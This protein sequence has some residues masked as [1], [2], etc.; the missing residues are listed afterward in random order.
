M[1]NPVRWGT[2]REAAEIAGLHTMTI[3]RYI[4]AGDLPARRVSKKLIQV[5]L[6]AVEC[7]KRPLIPDTDPTMSA[8]RAQ[9]AEAVPNATAAQLDAL[10]ETAAAAGIRAGA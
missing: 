7:L 4:N 9:L 6:D 2:V 8:L 10:I 5:D 1:S 3:R